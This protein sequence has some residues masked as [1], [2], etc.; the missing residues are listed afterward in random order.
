MTCPEKLTEVEDI[1]DIPAPTTDITEEAP[2]TPQ[3]PTPEKTAEP[4]K[5]ERFVVTRTK[6]VISKPVKPTV[7]T[8]KKKPKARKG[9]KS[10]KKADADS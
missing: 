10:V 1:Q 9:R 2:P 6:K 5:Q 3:V 8:L 7:S 4:A